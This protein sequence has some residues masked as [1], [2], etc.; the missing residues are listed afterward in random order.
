MNQERYN[1]FNLQLQAD[2]FTEELLKDPKYSRGGNLG[3]Y[4]GHMRGTQFDETAKLTEVYNR[5]GLE[6]QPTAIEISAGNGFEACS[7]YFLSTCNWKCWWAEKRDD[8]IN[9]I[10]SIYGKPVAEKRLILMKHFFNKEN[11]NKL[12]AQYEVPEEPDL[13]SID[14]DSND[15]WLWEAYEG[16]ARVI[17]IEYNPKIMPDHEWIMAY[18]PNRNFDKNDYHGA[19][20]KSLAIL[21]EKKGYDLVSCTLSG[22]N[23]IFVRKDLT[24]GKFDTYISPETA[25]VKHFEPARYY[26]CKAI[27]Q[28]ACM[29]YREYGSYVVE[30]GVKVN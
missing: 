5:I 17:I 24:M 2:A 30:D 23:A 20:L 28:G 21:G 29:P 19:S 25:A 26:I 15:Y 14:I 18:D 11:I 9:N 7:T 27:S 8:F 3:R 16:N 1:F 13:L 10:K 22:A 4:V 6:G 12:L